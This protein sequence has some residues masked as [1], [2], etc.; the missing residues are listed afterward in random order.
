MYFVKIL[1]VINY[2]PTLWTDAAQLK[3]TF[4]GLDYQLA[5]AEF[6]Y[7]DI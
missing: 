5:S 4:V 2:T 3:L 7:S 1:K 6:I